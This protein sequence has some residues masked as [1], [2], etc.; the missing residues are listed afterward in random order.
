M[1]PRYAS[2]IWACFGIAAIAVLWNVFA[3]LIE[4]KQLK[5]RLSESAEES[6]DHDA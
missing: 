6:T 2:F 1:D 5:Q 3:P 4:R